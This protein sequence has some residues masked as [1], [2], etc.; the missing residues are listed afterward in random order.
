[1]LGSGRR[2]RRLPTVGGTVV[3]E[4]KTKMVRVKNERSGAATDT[5][6]SC[7]PQLRFHRK[8]D[9]VSPLHFQRTFLY[10]SSRTPHLFGSRVSCTPL[11]G[12]CLSEEP[13]SA[14]AECSTCIQPLNYSAL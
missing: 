11:D 6:F 13:G 4:M 9:P 10:F 7:L 12:S 2:G 3:E 1:M 8:S 5:E 14:G